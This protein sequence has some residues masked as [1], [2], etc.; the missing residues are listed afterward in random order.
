ML[1]VWLVVFFGAIYMAY[2]SV[3]VPRKQAEEIAIKADVSATN[4]LS[5]RRAVQKYMQDHPAATG[6]IADSSLGPYWLHGYI[7]D[8]NWTN[9]VIGGD[10]YVYSTTSVDKSTLD[11]LWQK[12]SENLLF[13]TK[14]PVNGRL[15][16]Y[17][18]FDTGIVLP[19]SIPNNAVVIMGR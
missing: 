4:M 9:L 6:K 17:K 10:L 16:S 18:G 11:Y 3:E 2:V 7:R 13:G 15:R 8:A 12:T 19:A 1:P 5:Y 14:N